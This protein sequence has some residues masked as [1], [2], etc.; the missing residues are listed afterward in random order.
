MFKGYDI[1]NKVLL[2]KP[3]QRLKLI[4]QLGPIDLIFTKA[5]H[6]RFEHS[7]GTAEL[8]IKTMENMRN[9]DGES[10][11]PD[12]IE[13]IAIAGLLHDIGHG[14]FSHLY[15]KINPSFC[16]EEKTLK[17][18][19]SMEGI[20]DK[21]F[22]KDCICPRINESLDFPYC[23]INNKINGLDLDKIDYIVR[24]CK[25][26]EQ[27]V[28]FNQD[29]FN[30]IRIINNEIIYPDYSYND[31]ESIFKTRFFLY[32][33]FYSCKSI[34]R[35]EHFFIEEIKNSKIVF[36]EDSTDCIIDESFIAKLRQR[37]NTSKDIGLTSCINSGTNGI[38]KFFDD[39]GVIVTK[40]IS[41]R[42]KHV[43]Y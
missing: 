28:K 41:T 15:E 1:L 3:V 16:H 10:P 24:D 11:N 19:D 36:D 8:V 38:F 14:P 21:P 37:M 26:L 7:V 31:I 27:P 22:V 23:L 33:H 30:D 43:H 6:K 39:S 13:H 42:E 9:S 12:L 5:N 4:K 25:Y 35:L 17:I 40:Y 18:I 32:E 29:F 34:K 20:F 2:S